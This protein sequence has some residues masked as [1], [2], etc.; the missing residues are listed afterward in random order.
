MTNGKAQMLNQ[1]QNPNNKKSK[2]CSDGG[3]LPLTKAMNVSASE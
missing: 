1:A 2:Q 3:Y